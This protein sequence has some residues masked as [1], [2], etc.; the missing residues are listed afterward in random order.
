MR[1][2]NKGGLLGGFMK[3]WVRVLIVLAFTFSVEGYFSESRNGADA[4]HEL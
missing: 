3:G 2:P 4:R 1:R